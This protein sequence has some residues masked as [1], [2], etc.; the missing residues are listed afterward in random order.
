MAS[1]LLTAVM[2]GIIGTGSNAAAADVD[3]LFQDAKT[4]A[5]LLQRDTDKMEGFTLSDLS[6][7]AHA[8]EIELIKGHINK[9]GEIVS[10]L[11]AVRG[12]TESGTKRRSIASYRRFRD[13]RPTPQRS[14]TICT[15]T[16]RTCRIPVTR[17]T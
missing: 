13:R 5:A 14:S 10:Q 15:K 1:C 12:D 7:E 4:Q 8:A 3:Q 11:Q 17:S 2:S 16:T 9:L 6:W